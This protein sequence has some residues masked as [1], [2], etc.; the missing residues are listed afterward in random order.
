M[1]THASQL[2][3]LARSRVILDDNPAPKLR[4]YPRYTVVAEKLEA[5]VSLGM[6][7]S[8]MKDYFDLWVLVTC[9][10]FDNAV[11]KKA[12]R[13]TFE[14]WGTPLLLS[15]LS[16]SVT[17][18]RMTPRRTGSGKLSCARMASSR[19]LSGKS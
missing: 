3:D 7:N 16:A 12:I 17:N 6:L 19:N 14:R 8:R 5:L 2:L 1:E 11:L 9:A 10:E 15:N 4:A 18:S 13:A